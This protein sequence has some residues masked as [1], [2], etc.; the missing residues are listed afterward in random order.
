[1]KILVKLITLVA[2]FSMVAGCAGPTATTMSEAN[3]APVAE[4]TQPPA[5]EVSLSEGQ[6]WAMDNG[7]GP[8]TPETEDWAAIEA[9]A[10][11]EGSVVVYSNSSKIEKL[12]EPWAEL[13]PEIKLEG[14]DTDDI[15]VKNG[16][17][18]ASWKCCR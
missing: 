11:A 6:Q 1:M 12:L 13:Y 7:V 3:E 18:A 15:A 16:C 5:A 9:A 17:R 8:Y 14:G 10:I 4:A 2:L